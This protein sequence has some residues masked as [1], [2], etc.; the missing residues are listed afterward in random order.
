MPEAF[1]LDTCAFREAY[2]R[3]PGVLKI[4][5]EPPWTISAVT[6]WEL[7]RGMEKWALDPKNRRV[8]AAR[9]LARFRLFHREPIGL[10][11]ASDP[12]WAVAAEIWAR[13]A[14]RKPAVV[15]GVEDLLIFATARAAGLTLATFD[16]RL[17]K[18]LELLGETGFELLPQSLR[19]PD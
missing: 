9:N 15:V 19:S 6:A 8:G 5:G 10:V 14:V 13:A 2:K 1:L 16:G 17:T 18:L 4:V 3:L 11:G 12:A 7:R